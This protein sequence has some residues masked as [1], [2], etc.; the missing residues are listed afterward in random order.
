MLGA[1]SPVDL[2]VAKDDCETLA[3]YL[4][5]PVLKTVLKLLLGNN[6]RPEIARKMGKSLSFVETQVKRVQPMGQIN[7]NC[8]N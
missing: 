8:T 3:S 7:P 5:D 6:T 4:N 1:P 2:T